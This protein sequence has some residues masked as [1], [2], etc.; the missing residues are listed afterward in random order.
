M[1]KYFAI[2]LFLLS[3]V[4]V[5]SQNNTLNGKIMHMNSGK[6]PAVGVEV[7][8]HIQG[9]DNAN[10]RYTTDNGDFILAFQ[11]ANVGY[12]VELAIG[13]EDSYGN[14]LEVVN[15]KEVEQCLIPAQPT[16]IFE[17]V[18]C[19]KGERDLIAQ[20]YYNIIKTSA[21]R[22][23][24]ENQK[25]IETL[26]N[27]KVKDIQTIA[28]LS[29]KF[30]ELQNQ[31]DSLMIYKE[32]F[33][34]AS[35]NRDNASKRILE[36]LTALDQG[37]SIQEARA[38][39]SLKEAAKDLDQS[40]G[41]FRQ[42]LEEL[43]TIA[44]TSI[45]VY[46]YERAI[47]AYQTIIDRLKQVNFNPLSIAEYYLKLGNVY[48]FNADFNKALE[49]EEEAI[50]IQKNILDLESPI[51]A[52]SNDNISVTYSYLGKY[53]EAL[54]F[55]KKALTVREKMAE[56]NYWSLA[57]N[58]HNISSIY[59]AVG[60][61]KEALL[62]SKKS[63]E[64][65][66]TL[67]TSS[68]ILAIAYNGIAGIYSNLGEYEKALD[69]GKKA[70]SISLE[71]NDNQ[72][73]L[74]MTYSDLGVDYNKLG[75][76]NKAL[77]LNKKSLK[78]LEEKLAPDH[79]E[80]ATAYNNIASTFANLREYNDAL[81]F[82]KK[83]IAIYTKK[84]DSN[85][86]QLATAY[87]NIAS[88]YQSKG[89]YENALIF[90]K[91][92]LAIK[93]RIFLEGN[94]T[95]ALDFGNLA[96]NYSKLGQFEKAIQFQK[97]AIEIEEKNYDAMHPDLGTSYYNLGTI[98][99]DMHLYDEALHFIEKS[100]EI[101]E[102][103]LGSQHPSLS[104]SYNQM[105]SIYSLQKK[106]ELALKY[107]QKAVDIDEAILSPQHPDRAIG[108]NNMVSIYSDLK[109]FDKAI[110]YKKKVIEI[111]EKNNDST[112]TNLRDAYFTMSSLYSSTE[113]YDQ[114]LPYAEKY[115]KTTEE[116]LSSKDP[117]LLAGSYSY[118]STIYFNLG[119][120]PNSI[121]NL[122]KAIQLNE[123]IKDTDSLALATSYSDL[124]LSEAFT[125]NLQNAL[126]HQE[127]AV[128]IYKTTL[129]KKD[130]KLADAL[131]Y[132]GVYYYQLN[133]NVDA[134]K[135]YEDAAKTDKNIANFLY[136]NNLGMAYAKNRQF[137]EAEKAF[138]KLDKLLPDSPD[139]QKNW[140][141]F[142]ALQNDTGKAIAYLKKAVELGF[143]K[144]EWLKTD[145]SLDSI[146]N[147][148]EFKELLDNLEKSIANSSD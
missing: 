35:I 44:N 16:N 66:E 108:Y 42:A 148:I 58:Y 31:N 115:I 131:F 105:A 24:A 75:N 2:A 6:K 85:H 121:E 97:K 52:L 107:Q 146:R 39:L 71:K 25:K 46:D 53:K 123:S 142:Y 138:K 96:L 73:L 17:I 132:L 1:H 81:Q 4:K 43:N 117:L 12:K 11:N 38:A 98:Y 45:L 109:E 68:S 137:K 106:P 64:L 124:S 5:L 59:Q 7:S 23:L 120:Y 51:L 48:N 135:S 55:S 91:K 130:P 136:Y 74:A 41:G 62:F 69:Y 141:A 94:P 33:K 102:G 22:A 133:N 72:L 8:G 90:Q 3:C 127:K 93:E 21:D 118:L 63:I 89:D 19:K 49:Y 27:E 101:R 128:T 56:P 113:D 110:A 65:L 80:L 9:R 103:S 92:S 54:S 111:E 125:G 15:D 61:Y 10:K 20:K 139:A 60:Q 32:A 79:I 14:T 100:V 88:T 134:I 36:Y 78:I 18:V 143:K 47:T 114:A 50:K 29:V 145:T 147:E 67:D 82:A 119:Q 37:K 13:T 77:D 140:A 26:L 116:E 104:A 112:T 99:L 122:Q 57:N 40:I 30:K 95:F 144:I 76:Y 70:L 87:N 34:I 84:L 126:T 86:P 28:D 129:N 83:A